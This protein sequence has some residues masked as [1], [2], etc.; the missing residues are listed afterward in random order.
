MQLSVVTTMYRSAPYL[1]A[2]YERVTAAATALT[3]DFEIVF[4]NDGS[5]DDSLAIALELQR[6]DPRV[7][8]V[9]LSRNFGHHQ[10]MWTGLQHA[11]GDWVFLIDCDL[12]EAPEWV[13]LFAER[14][15]ATG[16]DVVFGVQDTRGGRW[17]D[18]W[19]GWA[20]YKLFNALCDDPIP[21]NL[22]TVRLMSRRYVSALLEHHEAT[23]VMSGL[24]A[25][26]GFRQ[27]PLPVQKQRKRDTTYSLAR[28]ARMF[29]NSVTSF[30]NRPLVFSFYLGS[31]LV[32]A[33]VLVA[34]GLVVGKLCF[35]TMLS[36]WPSLMVSIWFL[37]GLILFFQGVQGIYLAKIFLEAKRRPIAIVR[38]VYEGPG[39]ELRDSLRLAR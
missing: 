16:S 13:G 27:T 8:V 24:W 5:P 15:E 17:V 26:T 34:S 14:Q 11:R 29:V 20:F 10:A 25:R 36:G 1:G 32:V 28:R 2:F 21:E 38:Q 3:D 37:G 12:E 33:A 6:S 31:A 39:E 23:I 30:S 18:R 7:R 9:D 22:M 35:G 19:G 4:V